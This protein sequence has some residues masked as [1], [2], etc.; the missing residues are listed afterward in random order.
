MK[1]IMCLLIFVG[2]CCAKAAEPT[3]NVQVCNKLERV[4]LSLW[5]MMK[6]SMG[7]TCMDVVVPKSQAKVGTVLSSESRWYQGSSLNPTK[8]SVTRIK[9][10]Y[11]CSDDKTE[12][13]TNTSNPVSR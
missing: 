13:R 1:L 8:K 12:Q 3:C 9:K 2:G 7:E 5:S 4:T 6:D 11:R 10:V